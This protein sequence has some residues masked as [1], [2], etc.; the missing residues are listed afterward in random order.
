MELRGRMERV[1][2]PYVSFEEILSRGQRRLRLKRLAVTGASALVLAL[3]WVAIGPLHLRIPGSR[4]PN[5][6]HVNHQNGSPESQQEVVVAHGSADGQAWKLVVSGSGNRHLCVGVRLAAGSTESCGLLAREGPIKLAEGTVASV[7]GEYV[8][9]IAG[10]AVLRLEF[11]QNGRRH[12]LHLYSGPPTAP[13]AQFFVRWLPRVSNGSVI[14]YAQDGSVLNAVQLRLLEERQAAQA[15]AGFAG[16]HEALAFIRKQGIRD[17]VLPATLPKGAH[18][19][20]HN[21]VRLSNQG[22]EKS[23]ILE[24]RFGKGQLYFMYGTAL[25]DGCGAGS[26]RPLNLEGV[27][28]LIQKATV[29][30]AVWTVLIWPATPAHPQGEAGLGGNISPQQAK[31]LARSMMRVSAARAPPR[32]TGC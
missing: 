29:G 23:A 15:A 4:V 10:E 9:G 16:I 30:G 18:L 5:S 12:N 17:A 27:P 19:A 6:V 22:S 14:S 25:F 31:S 8:Y 2:P 32:P 28:A 24:L 20:P 1:T 3:F 21:P 26:A 7:K 13:G 11:R